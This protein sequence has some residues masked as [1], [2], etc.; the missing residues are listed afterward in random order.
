MLCGGEGCPGFIRGSTLD[1][2][3]WCPVFLASRT[4]F[5]EGRD[6][7]G[8]LLSTSPLCIY[9]LYRT[10]SEGNGM[11]PCSFSLPFLPPKT[12]AFG[13]TISNESQESL[14]P[15]RKVLVW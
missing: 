6:D 1:G 9:N 7:S 14:L 13:L 10:V 3:L 2:R 5:L 12:G 11:Y 4:E 15:M 8:S